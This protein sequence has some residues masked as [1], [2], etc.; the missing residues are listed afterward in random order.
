VVGS[1]AEGDRTLNLR[2]ANAML[3][4]LSYRPSC[5]NT[6]TNFSTPMKQAIPWHAIASSVTTRGWSGARVASCHCV[7]SG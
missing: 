5:W 7:S 1:G 2:I 3:S 6:K 4:Q